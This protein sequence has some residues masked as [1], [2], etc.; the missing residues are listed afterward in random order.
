MQRE[1]DNIK[2]KLTVDLGEWKQDMQSVTLRYK[3]SIN[4]MI[5]NERAR[6]R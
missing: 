5:D 4:Q 6:D 1:L 2:K 3:K